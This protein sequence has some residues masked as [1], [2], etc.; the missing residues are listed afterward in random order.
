M[1]QREINQIY[2]NNQENN[3]F[4][5]K[6]Q[7]ELKE[8]T[9]TITVSSVI[10]VPYQARHAKLV[11]NSMVSLSGTNNISPKKIVQTQPKL[12]PT[13]QHPLI[14]LMMAREPSK[15]QWPTYCKD[16]KMSLINSRD[17]YKVQGEGHAINVAQVD[18]YA[19]KTTNSQNIVTAFHAA[20]DIF[21]K[22]SPNSWIIN[23]GATTHMCPKPNL[24][25]DLKCTYV[26]VKLSDNR[27]IQVT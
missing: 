10:I 23:T 11:S 21:S 24:F 22:L 18:D 12:R 26:S 17:E 14:I 19:G 27:T 20:S 9:M 13:R 4:F 5:V 7:A 1:K 15:I 6:A 2:V 25:S 16:Y 3:A 8:E